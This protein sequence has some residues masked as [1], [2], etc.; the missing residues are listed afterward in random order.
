MSL[1]EGA[2]LLD[3]QT[4]SGGVATFVVPGLAAGLHVLTADYGGDGSNSPASSDA[5]FQEVTLPT[6]FLPVTVTRSGAGSG[7]VTS[8]PAGIDCGASCFA[9]FLSGSTVTLTATPSLGSVFVGWSGACPGAAACMLSMN[10]AR[11]VTARFEPAGSALGAAPT[12]LAFGGQSMNTTSPA[13]VVTLTNVWA[14]RSPCSTLQAPSGFALSHDCATLTASA[15][16]TRD[17][18]LH[19]DRR[20]RARRQRRGRD[21]HAGRAGSRVASVPVSGTGEKS[22]VT[23]YYRSILRRA[24]DAGGKAFWESEAARM[25][26]LGANVNETWYSMAGAFYTS[27]EYLAFARDDNGFVTDLYNTFFNRAPDAGGLAFWT[28]QLAGGMPRE[29]ALVSF[30]FSTEFVNFTQAIFGVTAV[31]A[32]INTVV[33]FYRGLLGRLPDNGGFAFW[34]QQ[35]RTAQCQGPAF[36]TAQAEAISSLFALSPEYSA[37]NRN[38]SQYVGDLYNAFLQARRRSSRRAL[39][40]QPDRH[41]RA[42]PRTGSPAVRGEPRVPESASPPSSPRAACPDPLLVV[43]AKAGTQL[44]S[45]VRGND[46]AHFVAGT[47]PGFPRPRE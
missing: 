33:D 46:N 2:A 30:M 35:F 13:Q 25:L 8:L 23:H 12:S 44:D 17:G 31:R 20:R 41:Q 18:E 45:R 9:D 7:T 26:T 40:D 1:R 36:V 37:R 28:G 10:A 19:A 21:L 6:V 34:V 16:C 22:L 32:E 27:A 29:V 43:P 5:L 15:S 11:T 39:L 38:T 24:P 47:Q 4:L 42:E 3:T 14:R